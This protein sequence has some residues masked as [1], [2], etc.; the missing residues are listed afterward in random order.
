M[1]FLSAISRFMLETESEF[2][3]VVHKRPSRV[4]GHCGQRV[5]RPMGEALESRLALATAGGVENILLPEF[6]AQLA[7][8]NGNQLPASDAWWALRSQR[9]MALDEPISK[10]QNL[11]AHNAFNSL[12]EGFDITQFL[13]PNQILSLSGQLD[14]GA[15]L[16]ELDI[17]D[18]TDFYA[19]SNDGSLVFERRLILRHGPLPAI[20]TRGAP[21]QLDSALPEVQD[22]LARPD[23]QNEIIFLDFEDATE[24]AES[25]ADDPLLP[26]LQAAF[27]SL[28]YTPEERAADG[29]WP[30]R[31]ELV[32]RGKRV[33]IFSHRNDEFHGRFGVPQ[34][35]V[36]PN[37]H[38]WFGSSMAFRANGSG[39]PVSDRG[40]FTQVSTDGF[41]FMLAP[42]Q[43]P[44]LTLE[45]IALLESSCGCSIP[46]FTP[47]PHPENADFFFS[48][49]GDSLRNFTARRYDTD[50]VAR[51]ARFNV[52]FTKMDFLFGDDED[53]DLGSN[54]TTDFSHDGFYDIP[55]DNRIALLESAVWSWEKNDPAVD[56]QMFQDLIPGDGTG[57]AL[58]DFLAARLD[59]LGDRLDPA[60]AQN[61]ADIGTA[62]RSNGRD[63]AYQDGSRWR[64]F[65][66]LA[67]I[68][69]GFAARSVSP[70]PAGEFEWR[71]TTGT[72][73]DWF[74]G[75]QMV[76]DEF[77]SGFVFGGP[78]NGFQNDQLSDVAGGPPV[79]IKVHDFD[80]DG[81]WQ[82]G[83]RAPSITSVNVQPASADEGESVQLTVEFF[84]APESHLLQ[85]DWGDGSAPTLVPV[86]A[87]QTQTVVI[88]H[89]YWDDHPLTGTPSDNFSIGVTLTDAGGLADEETIQITVNNVPPEIGAFVSDASFAGAADEGEPVN[90]LA[91]FSDEGVLDTHMAQVDWGDG[92]ALEW[93]TVN[94][95]AGSGTVTGSHVY[96][97]G[98]IYTIKLSVTDDDTGVATA[99]ATAI[100][101]GVGLSNGTL[102]VIGS[103]EKDHVNLNEAG[104]TRVKVN[105][106]FISKPRE[107]DIAAVSQIIAYLG[108]GDDQLTIS[109][110]LKIPAVIHGGGGADH[111]GGGGG[112]T[113]LLGEEGDD[114]LLGNGG[115]GI[116]IG[117]TGLDQSTAGQG[118]DVLLGGSTHIDHDDQALM[119]AAL[120]WN[121]PEAFVIRVLVIDGTIVEIDDED[122]DQLT[123]GSD[124]D[125]FYD[126]PGDF[127]KSLKRDD[128]VR[129]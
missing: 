83:N 122:E 104:Q 91:S 71:V 99:T 93:V 59:L 115:G 3:R 107:F 129:M 128:Q 127:L 94:Q 106:D 21:F 10:V 88:L 116:L 70:N 51:A 63:V 87:Q 5:Y 58:F 79:W 22:W 26:K 89:T 84:D 14:V 123:G 27:G 73:D 120:A 24:Q 11:A 64:S 85:V 69:M 92:S 23:N 76:R 52:D 119:A 18:P 8:P 6:I 103:S 31:A 105:A 102:Y 29:V 49:Q 114:H 50:T 77:G 98:G 45:E 34:E 48:V 42:G 55:Q 118:G 62:A 101:T 86:A 1:R 37:G 46:D 117:G 39:D 2:L 25:G 109:N 19:D 32:A 68:A 65:A 35:F 36:D 125:L 54:F 75:D 57:G 81:N 96:S 72:S 7:D 74:A 16:I 13:S 33:I 113:V 124:Q 38:T 43:E 40:N 90:I 110:Q 80:R 9:N 66:P 41:D 20:L 56:R 30:S 108:D 95:I 12:N 15:R 78:V 121:S 112:P 44:P 53:A 67:P 126:G 61:L 17:H 47:A 97:A 111:L 28:I 100:V 4:K 60:T 82:V